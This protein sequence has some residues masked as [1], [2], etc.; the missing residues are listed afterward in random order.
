MKKLFCGILA[1]V[2]ILGCL[3]GCSNTSKSDLYFETLS[4]TLYD[5]K[6]VSTDMDQETIRKNMKESPSNTIE[7]TDSVQ[8]EW[9]LDYGLFV[10]YDSSNWVSYIFVVGSEGGNF[11]TS[12]GVSQGDSVASMKEKLGEPM[13]EDEA[14]YTYGFYLVE[15]RYII[16]R[17]NTDSFFSSL[18]E[19]SD[20]NAYTVNFSTDNDKIEDFSVYHLTQ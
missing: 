18:V 2:L 16:A 9:V 17:G 1:V 14:R 7:L 6:V 12:L 3:A 10:D 20:I 15:G 8:D 19:N 13:E 11:T 4:V 5:G